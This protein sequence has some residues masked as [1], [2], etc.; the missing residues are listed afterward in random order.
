MRKLTF[1]ATAVVVAMALAFASVTIAGD[2]SQSMAASG[3]QVGAPA[4]QFSL[5]D[6]TGKT[7]SLAD[8][9]GKIVV[10]EWFNEGCPIVQRHYQADTMNKLA[11]KY[12]PQ[13][14]VWLAVNS[15]SGSTNDSNAKAAS[16]WKMDRPILNDAEGTVGHLYGATNTPHMYIIDKDGKLAYAGAI[17][18]DPNGKK[19][20]GKVNYVEK[21]LDEL[22]AGNSVSQPQTKAYGC[23]VHYA[24]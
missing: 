10:L 9:S 3:A 14:V 6:Q 15:T 2:K 22:L 8:Q 11:N 19:T 17:D 16:Q 24:K 1:V 13:G 4:P 7:V 18:N 5:P 21:A 23:G 20:D 12:G